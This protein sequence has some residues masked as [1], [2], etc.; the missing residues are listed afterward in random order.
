MK[1]P[2]HTCF[3]SLQPPRPPLPRRTQRGGGKRVSDARTHA[4]I[5]AAASVAEAPSHTRDRHC[6]STA[7][8]PREEAPSRFI[9][10]RFFAPLVAS[11]GRS[12]RYRSRAFPGSAREPLSFIRPG[13]DRH[14]PGNGAPARSSGLHRDL[15]VN[16]FRLVHS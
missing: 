3:R 10:R 4:Y 6:R 8:M 13:D 12:A 9:L 11:A 5:Y 16:F 7:R 14:Q 2:I 15:W 1:L